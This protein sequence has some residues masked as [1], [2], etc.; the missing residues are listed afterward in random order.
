MLD[1]P[2]TNTLCMQV[3]TFLGVWRVMHLV[4]PEFIADAL[5][6]IVTS[7]IAGMAND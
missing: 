1:Y 4:C 7:L 3:F 5:T 6:E 2:V